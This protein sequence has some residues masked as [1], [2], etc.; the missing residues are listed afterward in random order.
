MKIRNLAFCLAVAVSTIC[1]IAGPA[2]PGPIGRS[3]IAG[4]AY[5]CPIGRSHTAGP[6]YPGP[7]G[8]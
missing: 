4:P 2:Y 5:P 7:I 6:A 1:A 3:H 8:R